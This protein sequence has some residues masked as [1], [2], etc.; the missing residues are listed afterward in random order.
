MK[1][2]KYWP[3]SDEEQLYGQ[4]T[5]KCRSV[6][7]FAEYTVRTFTISKVIK[8]TKNLKDK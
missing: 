6:E 5:V 2:E 1:C 4:I 8:W 3:N 7:E